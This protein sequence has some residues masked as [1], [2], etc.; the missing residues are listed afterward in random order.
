[1]GSLMIAVALL[2]FGVYL[3]KHFFQYGGTRVVY[4]DRPAADEKPKPRAE[5]DRAAIAKTWTLACAARDEFVK[6][7][8]TFEVGPKALEDQLF[9]RR[10]LTDTSEPLTA[11]WLDA[12]EDFDA[13]FPTV[14]P[15]TAKG[16]QDALQLAR[17]TRDAWRA[18]DK[19]ARTKGIG[20]LSDADAAKLDTAQRLL[21]AARDR[22]TS[23]E[24]RRSQVLKISE[25][26]SGLT[27]RPEEEVT[28]QIEKALNPWLKS[29]GAPALRLAIES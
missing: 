25:I 12:K 3:V 22:G 16:A 29:I 24:E 8:T 5:D 10:L 14:Q 6:E 21:T 23:A 17:A 7:F 28:A 20:S 26:M 18:A 15:T 1:M 2:T 4:R 19:N 9:K 13:H 27:H 11:A